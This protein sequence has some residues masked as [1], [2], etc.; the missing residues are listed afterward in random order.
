MSCVAG[1]ITVIYKA[2]EDIESTAFAYTRF[3]VLNIVRELPHM[4][5]R[6]CYLNNAPTKLMRR[7]FVAVYIYIYIYI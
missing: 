4:R 2:L 3:H 6:S 5:Q 7:D 1:L